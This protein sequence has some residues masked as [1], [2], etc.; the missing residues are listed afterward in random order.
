MHC[1]LHT[2]ALVQGFLMELAWGLCCMRCLLWTSPVC[3]LH[4]MELVCRPNPDWPQIQHTGLAQWGTTRISYPGSALHVVCSLCTQSSPI[5]CMQHIPARWGLGLYTACGT[6][7]V[8]MLHVAHVSD[9][10]YTLG[11]VYRA[12]LCA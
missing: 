12:S 6:S 3:W 4:C 8:C 11:L 9:Q 5:P 7:T 1:V 10:P 2:P